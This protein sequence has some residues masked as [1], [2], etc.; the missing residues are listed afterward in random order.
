MPQS[1]LFF[2]SKTDKNGNTY[3]EAFNRYVGKV[4][5]FNADSDKGIEFT[6]NVIKKYNAPRSW[7]SMG[8]P[9]SRRYPRRRFSYRGRSTNMGRGRYGPA[10]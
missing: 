7:R 6:A 5:L 2:K 3:Y 4:L 1:K 8:Y 10:Y 9:P